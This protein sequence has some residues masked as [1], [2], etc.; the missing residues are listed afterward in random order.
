MENTSILLREVPGGSGPRSS[1]RAVRSANGVAVAT[2][3]AL[4]A[5]SQEQFALTIL[6]RIKP[7]AVDELRT[8]L[9]TIGENIETNPY[10][11]F[12]DLTT[13][14]Y[15]RFVVLPADA[16]RDIPASV[17][18]ESNYDGDLDIHLDELL[19][20]GRRGIDAIYSKC[21]GWPG[22]SASPAAIK[23]FLRAQSI[24]YA[25]FYIGHQGLSRRWI[26]NDIAVRKEIDDHLQTQQKTPG[27]PRS[28]VEIRAGIQKHLAKS[29]G[30][31]TASFERRVPP[32]TEMLPWLVPASLLGL[33]FLPLLLPAVLLW[34]VL[35]RSHEERDQSDPLQASFPITNFVNM[36]NHEIQNPLTHLVPIKPG[37]F[38]LLTLKGV[39]WSINVLARYRYNQGALGGIPSIHF[40]RWAIIDGGK[41]LLFFSN[42]D[43]SWENYLG[44]F[45]DK[46]S[47]GLTG[48]WSNTEGFPKTRWLVNEGATHEEP[49]KQWTRA[50]QIPTQVWYAAYPASTVTN[51]LNNADVRRRVEGDLSDAETLAWLQ[52]V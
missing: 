26:R 40:A 21:E 19:A 34:A 36:E 16:D 1:T 47:A 23:A 48:I 22:D 13:T 3:R 12:T 18:F 14:H 50:H 51:V 43:G 25:A 49:F 31:S 52:K 46:A 44:D 11:K 33:A 6:A 32:W 7:G 42:Y 35:L 8:L 4:K 20:V 9:E 45:I 37:L 24:P 38:R 10:I 15:C 30:L 17:S 28:S 5:E 39:L 29:P 2:P 41:R 27:W